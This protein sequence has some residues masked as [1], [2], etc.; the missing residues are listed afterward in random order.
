ME[1]PKL[2]HEPE[3]KKKRNCTVTDSNVNE[4]SPVSSALCRLSLVTTVKI[5]MGDLIT[6]HWHKEQE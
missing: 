4:D 5:L 2:N 3:G 6:T 1:L